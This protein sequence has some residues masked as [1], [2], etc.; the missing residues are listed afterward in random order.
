MVRMES[1]SALLVSLLLSRAYTTAAALSTQ[2]DCLKSISGEW[3]EAKEILDYL[4]LPLNLSKQW[5]T[6]YVKC[7]ISQPRYA[8]QSHLAPATPIK[9]PC[10]LQV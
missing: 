8:K 6:Y 7:F 1:G 4:A 3:T 2:P 10:H 5:N 9:S